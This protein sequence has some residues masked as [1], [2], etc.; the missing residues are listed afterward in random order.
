[1]NEKETE[2]ISI[3]KEPVTVNVVEPSVSTEPV[4]KTH[5][6]GHS[7]SN[8]QTVDKASDDYCLERFKKNM[9]HNRN[10]KI[11]IC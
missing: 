6:R 9:R 4:K 2:S 3:D 8:N 11:K 5:K 1:M 7:K 10:S